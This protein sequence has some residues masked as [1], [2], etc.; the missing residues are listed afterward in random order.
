MD[1]KLLAIDPGTIQSAFVL[2]DGRKIFNA[3]IRPNQLIIQYIYEANHERFVMEKVESYGMPVGA[4][5]FDTVFWSGRFVEAHL[6]AA[7]EDAQVQSDKDYYRMPRREVKLHLCNSAR[8][9]DGNIRQALIDRFGPI[10]TKKNPNPVHGD[11]K[12]RKDI[13][14]AFA[15]AVTWWDT[16]RGEE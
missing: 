5:V 1:R 11:V 4:T 14:A 16:M 10:T 9:K 2:W 3:D 12:I 15:L 8:A 13:W 7:D 6:F